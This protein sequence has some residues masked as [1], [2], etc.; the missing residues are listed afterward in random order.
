MR[1]ITALSK[2][3][4]CIEVRFVKRFNGVNSQMNIEDTASVQQTTLVEGLPGGD[5]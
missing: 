3:L 4:R 1:I 2:R 5:G